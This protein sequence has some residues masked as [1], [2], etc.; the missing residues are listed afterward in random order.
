MSNKFKQLAEALKGQGQ[1]LEI[2][3]QQ[4]QPS[5]Q[6]QEP[7]E[8]QSKRKLGKRSNPDYELIGLYIPKEV[9]LETKRLLIGKKIDF[10]DLVT[11]LLRQWLK[12]R[13]S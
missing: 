11:N 10:S 13:S 12:Q 4:S 8:K 1:A 9:N 3:V 5:I 6:T 2:S 7:V